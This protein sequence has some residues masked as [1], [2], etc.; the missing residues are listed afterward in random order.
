MSEEIKIRKEDNPL[1][2][3]LPDGTAWPVATLRDQFAMAALTALLARTDIDIIEFIDFAVD[4]Y[5]V[6]DAMI[7]AREA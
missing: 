7:K 6:A 2:M 5:N 3:I 4:S 1:M